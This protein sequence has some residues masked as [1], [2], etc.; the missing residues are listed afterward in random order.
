MTEKTKTV[1]RIN[2]VSIMLFDG[3]EKLVPIK[4]ICEAIVI[5][6]KAK[7]IRLKVMKY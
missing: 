4:P 7:L 5:A 1:A 2:D 6:I 3:A